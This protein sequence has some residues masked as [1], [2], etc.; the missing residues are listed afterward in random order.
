MQIGTLVELKS[1]NL[2]VRWVHWVIASHVKLKATTALLTRN[3]EV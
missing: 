2:L 3:K 1:G